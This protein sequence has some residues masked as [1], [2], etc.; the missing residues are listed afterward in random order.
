MYSSLL[1]DKYRMG[2]WFAVCG[3][4]LMIVAY[5]AIDQSFDAATRHEAVGFKPIYPDALKSRY[6]SR[7]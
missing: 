1:V 5:P 7:T 3:L 6:S 4:T 2:L